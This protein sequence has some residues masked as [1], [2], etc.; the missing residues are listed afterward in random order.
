VQ[1]AFTL[2]ISVAIEL[3]PVHHTRQMWWIT[4][5]DFHKEI[6]LLVRHMVCKGRRLASMAFGWG[7]AAHGFCTQSLSI[8]GIKAMF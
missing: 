8:A 4:I 7:D 2:R 5:L 6:W 3:A 1:H